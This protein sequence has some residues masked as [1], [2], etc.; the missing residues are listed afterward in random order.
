MKFLDPK[1]RAEPRYEATLDEVFEDIEF[2]PYSKHPVQRE[3]WLF[4][5]ML[6][7]LRMNEYRGGWHY[8]KFR[9]QLLDMLAPSIFSNK[10]SV[11]HQEL[12]AELIEQRDGTVKLYLSFTLVSGAYCLLVTSKD[13]ALTLIDRHKEA[14]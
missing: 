1:S 5:S 4:L 11:L 12:R 3:G 7:M 8:A 6:S 10:A 13:E 2:I 9:P 14:A